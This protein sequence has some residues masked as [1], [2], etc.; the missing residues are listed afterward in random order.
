VSV[1]LAVFASGSGSNLQA[2]LNHF[3]GAG[4]AGAPGR[5]SGEVQEGGTN[6]S[7]EQHG[8]AGAATG[9][10]AATN[11]FREQHG[12]AGVA[13]VRLVVSDRPDAG[14]LR[15]AETSGIPT[16]VIRVPG[17]STADVAA[18]TLDALAE[19]GIEFIALAGYLRLV[20]VPVVNRFAG[21]I[22][23]IH[24]A[25]LPAFGG[26][27]MYGPRIHAEVISAGCTVSGAT[28]HH[29]DEEYD[30]GRII[31]QWPVPV[32]PNDDPATLAARVLSVEHRLYPATIEWLARAQSERTPPPLHGTG[33]TLASGPTPQ[34][35]DIQALIR[36]ETR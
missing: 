23:N 3:H 26:A 33:Y 21:R 30:R 12:S 8:S 36:S 24:P 10:A 14:A 17:R 5:A 22:V 1:P 28:V 7:R 18:E 16:R 35:Q 19:A 2:I 34:P 4:A 15:R 32:L 13:H 31:A 27:G 9:S 29:V 6:S 11:S 25:L 20:P